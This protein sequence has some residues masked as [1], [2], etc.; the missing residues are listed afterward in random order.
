MKELLTFVSLAVL[1]TGCAYTTAVPIQYGDR[2]T[3]GFRVYDPQTLLI[4]TCDNA[5]V[6]TVP[7]YQRGYALQAK[8]YLA[9]NDTIFKMEG[10]QLAEVDTKLDTTAL[11]S[12]LQSWGERALDQV[13]NLGALGASVGGG[14]KGMEGV[15]LLRADQTGA[16]VELKQLAKAT[17]TCP[18]A[19]S[20]AATA[21]VPG[22]A[23]N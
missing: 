18:P 11:L 8:A 20:G 6:V 22:M 10:G 21:P 7:D 17:S 1:A 14:L 19:G 16:M 13:Q 2:E 5:E 23:P 12:L 9:K 4:V 15:W 3:E